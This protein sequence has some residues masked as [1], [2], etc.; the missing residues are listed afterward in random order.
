MAVHEYKPTF[1][2]RLQGSQ[3]VDVTTV[4][5]EHRP[6]WQR[7]ERCIDGGISTLWFVAS[8]QPSPETDRAED[9]SWGQPG[10]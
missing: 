10:D 3:P 2:L 8:G 9:S 7:E 1:S 6:G 5:E 4:C